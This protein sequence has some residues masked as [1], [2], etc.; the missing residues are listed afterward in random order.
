MCDKSTDKKTLIN[1]DK[2]LI[3]YSKIHNFTD[4]LDQKK[5]YVKPDGGTVSFLSTKKLFMSNKNSKCNTTYQ[6]STQKAEINVNKSGKIYVKYLFC[7]SY[8]DNHNHNTSGFFYSINDKE[9]L[10]SKYCEKGELKI[11]LN[12]NDKFSFIIKPIVEK[13]LCNTEVTIE[14]LGYVFNECQQSSIKYKNLKKEAPEGSEEPNKPNGPNGPN[15]PNEPKC[16]SH[17]GENSLNF[18]K[19]IIISTTGNFI[20]CSGT[21]TL[22]VQAIG[23]GAAGGG[24]SYIQPPLPELNS[25]DLSISSGSGGGAGGY[26]EKW[27]K[28]DNH[29]PIPVIIG[30]GGLGMSGATGATGSDTRFSTYLSAYGGLGGLIGIQQNFTTAQFINYRINGG[31]GGTAG[32]TMSVTSIYDSG[33]IIDGGIGGIAKIEF[34]E[35]SQSLV[36][37]S[38]SGGISPYGSVSFPIGFNI[39]QTDPYTNLTMDGLTGI[40]YG[41]GGSGSVYITNGLNVPTATTSKG[42]NGSNGVVIVTEYGSE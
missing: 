16:K 27:I 42:G 12:E 1:D 14:C 2:F 29:N 19:K 5:W 18:L 23:G 41:G 31:S 38:G 13:N 28:L 37:Q 39:L 30:Q 15:G 20:P 21:K 34:N 33:I 9:I 22:F 32:T 24:S 17:C 10:I 3:E 4:L 36:V 25:I 7:S 35:I 26:I 40:G 6:K 11:Y 8:K